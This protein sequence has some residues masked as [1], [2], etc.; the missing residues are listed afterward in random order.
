MPFINLLPRPGQSGFATG[1]VNG[2]DWRIP[3]MRNIEV[4]QRL[5]DALITA[6][7]TYATVSSSD[8]PF[9]FDVSA[10]T[11]NPNSSAP[12]GDMIEVI[13]NGHPVLVPASS[14]GGGGGGTPPDVGAAVAAALPA[15]LPG[16]LPAALATAGA[17]LD[18]RPSIMLLT[19][20]TYTGI[21]RPNVAPG[22]YRFK[23]SAGPDGK[24]NG[25][26]VTLVFTDA[27]GT[28]I[29]RSQPY[30][31]DTIVDFTLYATCTVQAVIKGNPFGLYARL[32][33]PAKNLDPTKY[34]RDIRVAG[35]TAEDFS[36]DP[37]TKLKFGDFDYFIASVPKKH[38]VMQLFD[39]AQG[40]FVRQFRFDVDPGDIPYKYG[41][42]DRAEMKGEV[43]STDFHNTLPYD[44]EV[45]SAMGYIFEPRPP[46]TGQWHIIWQD[47][48]TEDPGDSF[49]SP[50]LYFD[51]T[52]NNGVET[53]GMGSRT[54]PNPVNTS[55]AQTRTHYGVPGNMPL[56]RF[57]P[58]VIAR[59][60][61]FQG[62]ARLR[63][64]YGDN[65][66]YAN[67]T[68][69]SAQDSA[70]QPFSLG[71]NDQHGPHNAFGIYQSNL[72][73][74]KT[75]F[76]TPETTHW[77]YQLIE[78]EQVVGTDALAMRI[79]NPLPATLTAEEQFA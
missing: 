54:D 41:N 49:L 78:P 5:L 12:T 55:Q 11:T 19:H 30:T 16:A 33:P 29:D 46:L 14:V 9:K 28:V 65:A 63:M 43:S 64:W 20:A 24:W 59:K 53:F 66:T 38:P 67:P 36:S 57:I 39:E 69:D 13:R 2:A 18:L 4:T 34:W 6:G 7:Y 75:S 37:T 27:N 8:I 73:D 51:V 1:A 10:A 72:G 47:H 76:Y 35:V 68:Y 23:V 61:N 44:I 60:Y 70:Y 50:P 42:N 3:F 22:P 45:W 48:A 40:K 21:A 79:G 31:S 71:Y 15:V 25:A 62:L 77:A 52:V 26:S 56:G 58:V 32:A 74:Q 17:P